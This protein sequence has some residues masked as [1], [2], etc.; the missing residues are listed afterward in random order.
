MRKLLIGAAIVFAANIAGCSMFQNA[1][2][3][4]LAFNCANGATLLQDVPTGMLTPAQ[5]ANIENAACSTAF[6]TTAAPA[7][8]PGNNPVFPP[9]AP[10]SK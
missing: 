6:G 8:A 5:I 4:L 2:R 10:V 1:A 7:P 3:N 9:A